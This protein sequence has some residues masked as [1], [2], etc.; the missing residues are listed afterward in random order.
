MATR[1]AE[2]LQLNKC[3]NQSF[4]FVSLNKL[5]MLT[6]IQQFLKQLET[7][8]GSNISKEANK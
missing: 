3:L 4:I 7:K 1:I 2:I 8:H 6:T 5:R